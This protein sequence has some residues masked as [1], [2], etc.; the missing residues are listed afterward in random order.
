M[1]SHPIFE[2]ST[3]EFLWPNKALQNISP[4]RVNV[5][6]NNH[7]SQSFIQTNKNQNPKLWNQECK[8][9]KYMRYPEKLQRVSISESAF[10]SYTWEKKSIFFPV[11]KHGAHVLRFRSRRR[12]E[13]PAAVVM[14]T[15]VLVLTCC[16]IILASSSSPS[17][18]RKLLFKTLKSSVTFCFKLQA[19][20]WVTTGKFLSEF[21]HVFKKCW[22][23][24]MGV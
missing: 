4:E 10:M 24:K 8:K 18:L 14:G 2:I 5:L 22:L 9:K 1:I 19:K 11:L 3:R 17:V 20:S 21:Q 13:L 6:K 23:L 7:H 12:K 15:E 16:C